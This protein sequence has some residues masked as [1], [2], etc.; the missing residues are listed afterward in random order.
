MHLVNTAA[1]DLLYLL[2]LHIERYNLFLHLR[3][4]R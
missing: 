3:E 4:M 2:Y 1:I